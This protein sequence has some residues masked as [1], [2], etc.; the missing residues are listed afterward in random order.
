MR[1]QTN[2]ITKNS[3]RYAKE[4]ILYLPCTAEH[5]FALNGGQ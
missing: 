1:Q 4:L 5:G 3:S 2:Q